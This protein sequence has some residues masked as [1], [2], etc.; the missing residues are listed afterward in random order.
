MSWVIVCAK[1]LL[2]RPV[3]LADHF[4]PA[5]GLFYR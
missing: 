2:A 1:R 4:D 5:E 3:R